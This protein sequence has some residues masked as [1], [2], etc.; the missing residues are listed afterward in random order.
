MK[1]II[2]GHVLC[3]HTLEARSTIYQIDDKD[4]TLC[5]D[6]PLAPTSPGPM[7]IVQR[8]SLPQTLLT[9]TPGLILSPQSLSLMKP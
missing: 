9:D 2:T 4:S 1:E 8:I 3:I 6:R 5:K 7:T